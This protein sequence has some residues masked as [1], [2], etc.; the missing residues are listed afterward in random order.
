MGPNRLDPAPPARSTSHRHSG[1][2]NSVVFA[3]DGRTLAAG[4]EDKTVILWDV[5]D[6]AQFHRLG[7]PLTVHTGQV[8]SVALAPDGRIMFT[9]SADQTVIRWDLTDRAQPRQLGSPLTRPTGPVTSMALAPD[10]HTLV[11][12]Q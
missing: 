3:P 8:N 11:Y 2:V 12:R 6:R 7:S 1:T 10:G 4:S 5:T 9:G